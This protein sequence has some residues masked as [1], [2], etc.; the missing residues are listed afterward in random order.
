MGKRKIE[1]AIITG[2]TGV[3]GTAL[4]KRLIQERI[5]VYA[6]CRPESPRF[7]NLKASEFLHIVTCDIGQIKHLPELIKENC[8]VFFHLGW[9]KTAGEGRNDLMAQIRNIQNT[10]QAVQTAACLGCQVFVGAGS[11]AEYG[12]VNGIL[13]PATPVNPEN[14]Y[15]MAK[16]CAGQM[17]RLECEKLGM[18]HIWARVLSVYG[19]CDGMSTAINGT[20][21]KLLQGECP[22][23]TEGGQLWDY[24]Y[25]DDAADAFL[26]MASDGISGAVYVVGSG[27]ARPLRQ[28]MELLR[29][30]VDPE[31]PLGFGKVPYS[32]LQVMHLEADIRALQEDTGFLPKTSFEVGIRKT[33]DWVR[34][35]NHA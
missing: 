3:I 23:L 19:P 30:A 21:R 7:S 5:T 25:S 20:I 10:I 35:R 18:D 11:Q 27:E 14:G 32:P 16:L 1:K 6:V 31:L 34:D 22:G 9:E 33:I 29:D 26:R 12:R 4:C 24:L 8:D 17:S 15:G 13:S 2:P 28:Y